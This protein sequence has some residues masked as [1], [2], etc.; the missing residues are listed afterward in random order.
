MELSLIKSLLSVL[1]LEIDVNA[2]YP[3]YYNNYAFIQQWYRKEDNVLLLGLYV[4]RGFGN[5]K[6]PARRI[7]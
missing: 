3:I 7:W 5:S 2:V 4:K 1:R 6:N